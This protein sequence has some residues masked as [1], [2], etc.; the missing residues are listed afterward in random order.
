MTITQAQADALLADIKALLAPYVEQDHG[1]APVSGF[2][3]GYEVV[4]HEELP[5]FEHRWPNRSEATRYVPTADVPTARYTVRTAGGDYSLLIGAEH[6][7]RKTHG[8][9][10]RGRIVVFVRR[11]EGTS[12]LYPLVEF[13]ETDEPSADGTSLYAAGVPRPGAPRSLST[14]NDLPELGKVPHLQ[15]AELRRAD[16]VYTDMNNGPTLRLVVK[17][18]DVQA[19]LVHALWVGE[20]RGG[21]RLPRPA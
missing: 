2:L 11:G 18:T 16:E 17:V 6:E 9:H 12:N 20:S 19:M 14:A 7:G 5:G 3:A 15:Q 1:T 10:G 4:G 8:V 13:A 21:N